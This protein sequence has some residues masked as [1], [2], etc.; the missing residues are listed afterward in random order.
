MPFLNNIPQPGDKLKNSQGQLLGNNQQLDAS[1]L[2]DHYTFSDA[3]TDNGKHH[4]VTTIDQVTAPTIIADEPKMYGL[5]QAGSNLPVIQYS[6][7]WNSA[8]MIGSV[9]TPLT[10]LQSPATPLTI[11]SASN[12]TLFD[13]SGI[14][15]A[16]GFLYAGDTALNNFN[17]T[18]FMWTGTVFRFFEAQSGASP[19]Q[20]LDGGAGLLL[21]RNNAG[22]AQNNVYWTIELKRSE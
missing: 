12:A 6:R 4:Q 22:F 7:Y 9:P 20:F 16:F 8:L 21:V 17:A 18:P 10:A 15:R 2:I 13:F 5:K 3:T 1:F 11:N 19:L 14:A